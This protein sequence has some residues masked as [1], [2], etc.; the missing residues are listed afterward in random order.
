MNILTF[1]IEEWYIEKIYHGDRKEKYAEFNRVLNQILDLLDEVNTKATFFCVG[2]MAEDFSDVIKHIDKRGHEIGSHSDKHIWL[3]KLNK[4]SIIEDTQNAINSLENC[5]GKKILSYR[6]P[7]F[8]IGKINPWVFEILVKCGIE[9]DASVFPAV[10]DFGGFASFEQK[11]PSI[12]SY[13]GFKIKEFPIS[14]VRLFGNEI[15]FSGGCYF[16]FFP[17][18]YIQQQIKQQSYS[19]TYF[20]IGDLLTETKKRLTKKEYEEYF[21]E[22][23][24]LINRYKR[25]VKSNLGTKGAYEKLVTLIKSENFVSLAQAE[26]IIDWDLAPKVELK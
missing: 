4:N 17:L 2:K 23:G 25:Y 20:H 12:V 10:R 18:F 8:S 6:A 26:G 24:S 15:A 13:N 21:K 11:V 9:R 7:A 3:T 16:R 14:T 22:S 19:M 1:D 5:I